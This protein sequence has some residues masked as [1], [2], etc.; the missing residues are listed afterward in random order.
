MELVQKDF[1]EGYIEIWEDKIG[2]SDEDE[3]ALVYEKLGDMYLSKNK[4]QAFLCYENAEF[5]CKSDKLRAKIQEKKDQLIM[6]EDITLSRTSIVI[7]S[8][9]SKYLME[10]CLAS[11]RKNCNPDACDIVVVD[12]ASTDGVREWLQE[13]D[14]ITL[15]LCEEN[16]GLSEVYN[17]GIEASDEQNDIFLLNND[18]RMASNALFWLRMGL[19]EN[20]DVGATGCISNYCGNNQQVDVEFALPN[21]YLEYGRTLNIYSD[22]PYEEKNCLCGFAMLIRRG[23]LDEAGRLDE[24]LTS[25]YDD[26][27]SARILDAEYRLVVCHNSFI[28]HAK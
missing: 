22:N 15:V 8:Y 20:E 27:L 21:E 18:T 1:Q 12:N 14:D 26:D 24:N 2:K 13:Q 3:E 25:G 23:A 28:Y 6:S 17:L 16:V 19:Y 7:V 9:N 4:N 11:I 5:L 10:Q